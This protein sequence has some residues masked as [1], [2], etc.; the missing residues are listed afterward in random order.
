MMG[1][2]LSLPFSSPLWVSHSGGTL[3]LGVVDRPQW[4]FSG[5]FVAKP[6]WDL[7]RDAA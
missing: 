3:S 2:P 1:V 5:S 7:G 6:I 4:A